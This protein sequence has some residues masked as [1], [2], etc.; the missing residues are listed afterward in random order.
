M[1]FSLL[2]IPISQTRGNNLVRSHHSLERQQKLNASVRSFGVLQPVLC[3]K[4]GDTYELIAGH[5]RLEAAEANGLT[6]IPA[7]CFEGKLPE[8]ELLKLAF[9]ENNV[10]SAMSL[11][12]QLDGLS[13]V[14]ALNKCTLTKAAE[15]LDISQPVAS[16]MNRIIRNVAEDVLLQL[17]EAKIGLSF[18]YI[19][20]KLPHDE[21]KQ[22][23]ARMIPEK[24]SRARLEQEVKPEAK[25][26][27]RVEGEV[28]MAITFSKAATYE[29]IR[30]ALTELL[31]DIRTREQQ[32]LPI[33]ILPQVMR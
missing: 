12:D 22:I 26:T 3:Q 14:V 13:R 8:A 33:S 23:V 11:S 10:R 17:D 9:T 25:R 2:S 15:F 29:T 5:G 16:K 6:E 19:L 30:E 21:Q 4:V 24:W 1:K 7:Q 27:V 18:A 32:G 31:K 28:S 20:S